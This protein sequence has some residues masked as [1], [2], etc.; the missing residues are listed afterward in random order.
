MARDNWSSVWRVG[1]AIRHSDRRAW[2]RV[3]TV[4]HAAGVLFLCLGI[5][6]IV[7]VLRTAELREDRA[8]AISP[9]RA[10]SAA[11]TRLYYG[12]T[13]SDLGS[14]PVTEVF[15]DPVSEETPLPPGVAAWPAPGEA[16]VSPQLAKELVGEHE[17]V[18]G[19]VVGEIGPD[20]LETPHERRVY[21]RTDPST[22]PREN[23]RPVRGFGGSLPAF[24]GTGMKYAPDTSEAIILM[25]TTLVLPGV[26]CVAMSSGMRSD[27]RQRRSASLVA[28]G[29][30]RRDLVILDLAETLPST[31]WGSAIAL[32]CVA[33]LLAVDVPLPWLDTVIQAAQTRQS[34]GSLLGAIA[35]GALLSVAITLSVKASS[36]FLSIRGGRRRRRVRSGARTDVRI[37]IGVIGFA[38]AIVGPILM[39]ESPY[40]PLFYYVGVILVAL[41]LPA[42]VARL[43]AHV[44]MKFSRRGLRRSKARD[45]VSGRYLEALS[46][47][48]S[49]LALGICVAILVGGQAQLWTSILDGQS[50]LSLQ[51]RDRWGTRVV[52]VGGDLSD[53]P[54]QRFLDL[55]P[56][57]VG[58]VSVSS[59]GSPGSQEARYTIAASCPALDVLGIDCSPHVLTDSEMSDTLGLIA[60]FNS[61]SGVSIAP[62]DSSDRVAA[63]DFPSHA[64]LLS[65]SGENIDTD[66][67]RR[68]AIATNPGMGFDSV[69]ESE[70]MIANQESIMGNWVLSLS[71]VGILLVMAFFAACVGVEARSNAERLAPIGVVAGEP[72]LASRTAWLTTSLP[73]LIAGLTGVAAYAL[74]PMGLDD[75]LAG[76]TRSD[77]L[78]HLSP[79]FIGG[80]LALTVIIALWAGW[81]ASRATAR[82]AADW[83]P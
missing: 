66:A 13:L 50:Q 56:E 72:G 41:S 20:G 44:G 40:R 52:R 15:L 59:D 63:P 80:A 62:L 70:A 39:V 47:R 65:L 2:G 68:A 6:A 43:V 34:T 49:R 1:A 61:V 64:V 19:H 22:V 74:L 16:V 37:T 17:G 53:P 67:L 33:L 76:S 58:V 46:G 8:A 29:M 30:R 81:S 54:G 24:Y 7:V 73:V 21:I 3:V 60:P 35:I 36:R 26:V 4:S 32:G 48:S 27:E 51:A 38:V 77:T 71:S 57:D 45:L 10:G 82:A 75:R 12:F 42:L 25:L 5:V 23:L 69:G 31:L 9:I 55:L 14:F 11:E 28:I 78:V 83:L 18:F 79:E